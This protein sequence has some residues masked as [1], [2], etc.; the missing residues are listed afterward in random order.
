MTKPKSKLPLK[1]VSFILC[2]ALF[3]PVPAHAGL[4]DLFAAID[5][6]ISDLIGGTLTLITTVQTNIRSLYEEIVWPIGVINST[7]TWSRN[8]VGQYRSWMSVVYHLPIQSAQTMSPRKLEDTI[9]SGRVGQLGQLAPAYNSTYGSLPTDQ[10]APLDLRQMMDMN[11]SLAQDALKQT[12]ASDQAN[13]GLLKMADDM[14]NNA[15]LAPGTS[16]YVSASAYAA[17]LQTLAYQHKLLAAQLRE[18]GAHL[19]HQSADMK[20]DT[21]RTNDLQ[22]SIFNILSTR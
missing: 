4:G 7:R 5:S 16:S 15:T 1:L 2:L 17:T 8:L 13:E 18:E 6:T 20:R 12:V 11:D 3:A 9:L 10:Q 22:Q 14:E 19:A 21:Q